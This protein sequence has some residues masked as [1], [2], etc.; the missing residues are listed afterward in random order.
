MRAI[1]DARSSGKCNIALM[2]FASFSRLNNTS[3]DNEVSTV[4]TTSWKDIVDGAMRVQEECVRDKDTGGAAV[5]L[6][7]ESVAP[8]SQ[9]KY[10]I[11][12]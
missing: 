7:C 5:I 9:Q 3:S 2:S 8:R 1:A 10:C 12:C 4:G 6:S 11:C